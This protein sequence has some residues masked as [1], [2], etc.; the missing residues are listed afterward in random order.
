[1]TAFPVDERAPARDN[2]GM[3]GRGLTSVLITDI[4]GSTERAA[5]LGDRRWRAVLEQHDAIGRAT[6]AAHGG[7]WLKS[8]GD[9]MVANFPGPAAAIRCGLEFIEMTREQLEV[10]VRAGV[11]VGECELRE[12]DV[13]GIAVHVAVR[14]SGIAGGGELLISRTVRDLVAGDD[15]DFATAG[16]HTLKGV[17]GR[18]QLYRVTERPP[19][20]VPSPRSPARS[21]RGTPGRATTGSARSA[22]PAPLSVVLVDDHPL[23]RQTVRTVIE[24]G[25]TGR[26]VA[27][28]ADG[29][30]AVAVIADHRPDVVLMDMQLPSLSGIEATRAVCARLPGARV[31]VLSSND[32]P[33][34]VVEAVR[35]GA[36]GYLIK[37]ADADTIRSAVRRV[38]AGELVFPTGV[39]DAVLDALRGREA[40][41]AEPGPTSALSERERQVLELMAEG[42]SNRA[43]AKRLFLSA[44]TVET[45]VSA[46][47]DKLDIKPTDDVNRR[48]RAV[49]AYL[50]EAAGSGKTL[51]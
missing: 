10:D 51:S 1:V 50:Q 13:A 40:T 11:H 8:T 29:A 33:P 6:A 17:P 30:E 35:A 38:A 23:W 27:E 14:V 32:D 2:P 4:A 47:F 26:V 19:A 41:A 7:S 25:R 21:R 48:V 16:S 44:K 5:A 28:V 42:L 31:L 43:I 12:D 3:G 36:A 34:T 39:G 22:A 24:Q 46:V 18:W 9:G 37:T 45:H 20:T 49:V 15:F